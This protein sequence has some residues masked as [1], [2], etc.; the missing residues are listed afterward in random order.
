MYDQDIV[1]FIHELIDEGIREINRLT[2]LYT[3]VISNDS[4]TTKR[5][6][7]ANLKNNFNPFLEHYINV[8]EQMINDDVKVNINKYVSKLKEVSKSIIVQYRRLEIEMQATLSRTSIWD[9]FK[10]VIDDLNDNLLLN[11][12]TLE[13]DSNNEVITNIEQSFIG[14]QNKVD[15]F[16]LSIG[17]TNEDIQKEVRQVIDIHQ[18]NLLDQVG[19]KI[20]V[21]VYFG[22]NMARLISI[23]AMNKINYKAQESSFNNNAVLDKSTTKYSHI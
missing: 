15:S 5:Q 6:L 12:H 22:G 23:A 11:L 9:G 8:I 19:D 20:S 2:T 3:S 7:I 18:Y 17:I 4:D 10:V 14:L 16:L 21:L 13:K 1:I